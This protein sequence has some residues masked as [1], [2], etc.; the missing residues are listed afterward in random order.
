[1]IILMNLYKF[2]YRCKS[3]QNEP[4]YCYENDVLLRNIEPK[5]VK[6]MVCVPVVNVDGDVIAVIQVV[7]KSKG[8]QSDKGKLIS[9]CI[10]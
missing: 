10:H 4:H 7:N 2:F 9:N 6:N 8:D 5:D 3:V 1:M